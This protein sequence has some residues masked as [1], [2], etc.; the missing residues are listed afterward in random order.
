MGR[1]IY[2]NQRRRGE[3]F[4]CFLST[5]V[6]APRSTKQTHLAFEFIPLSLDDDND[7]NDEEEDYNDSNLFTKC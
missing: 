7:V 1:L 4:G 5:V 6:V 2:G 3:P